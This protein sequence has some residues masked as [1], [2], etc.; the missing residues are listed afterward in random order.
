MGQRAAQDPNLHYIDG[1]ALYGPEDFAELPLP[2]RLH[3]DAPS[4]RRIG[5]RFARLAFGPASPTGRT[6]GT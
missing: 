3:P 4:H 5:E 1:L 6:I 2:D